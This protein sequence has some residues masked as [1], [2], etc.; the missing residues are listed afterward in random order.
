MKTGFVSF[1]GRPNVGKSTLLNM[2]IGK[3]IAIMS[4]TAQTTR[5]SIQGIKTTNRGQMIIVD[6]PGIHKPQDALGFFMNDVASAQSEGVDCAAI[7]LPAN[8]KIGTGDAFILEQLANIGTKTKKIAIISKIDTIPKEK[9]LKKIME[10][11]EVFDFDA[12]VPVSAKGKDNLEKL[13]EV[14]FSF[15]EEGPMLYDEDTTTIQS[16]S[17]MVKEFVREKIYHLTKEEIPHSVAVV[18]DQWEDTEE[19]I[20]IIV[21]V[22][23]ERKSQKAI[24]I[25]KQGSMVREVRKQAERDLKR[26]FQKK[27][28][29][30]IWVKVEKNWRSNPKYLHQFGYDIADYK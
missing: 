13:E 18:L 5:T 1:I 29:L 28:H 24:I 8:E 30:E 4:P 27:V 15:F 6:T 12:I 9:L 11:S 21:S 16:D 22:V 14:I 25:G 20:E 23:V 3:K 10:V 26:H 19:A 7:L 17:F 2:I